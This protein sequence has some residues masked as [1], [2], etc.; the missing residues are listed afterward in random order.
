MKRKL[1]VAIPILLVMAA[2]ILILIFT[3]DK[4]AEEQ[5]VLADSGYPVSLEEAGTDLRVTLDGSKTG[6]LTWSV[7]AENEDLI[8]I[9][10]QGEEKNGKATYVISP[11]VA[12][13]TT[14]EFT[15]A[16]NGEGAENTAVRIAIPI[17]VYEEEE[18]LRVTNAEEAYIR[19]LNETGGASLEYPYLLENRDDGTAVIT[20][21]KGESDWL[22]VDPDGIVGTG[23]MIGPE[24]ENLRNVYRLPSVEAAPDTSDTSEEKAERLPE[25]YRWGVEMDAQGRSHFVLVK[26][27]PEQSSEADYYDTQKE[28]Y[29]GHSSIAEDGS[30]STLLLAISKSQNVTEFI[31]VRLDGYGGITISLGKEPGK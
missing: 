15:R 12:G 30:G 5:K 9:A 16:G 23:T 25:G 24:G 2:L 22:F 13:Y 29:K 6:D 7:K 21:P 4:G 20:F 3:R 1:L 8:S 10:M 18:K 26:D 31:D 28:K 19:T 11:K 14:V 17:L 27:E